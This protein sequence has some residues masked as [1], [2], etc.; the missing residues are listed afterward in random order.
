M[1]QGSLDDRDEDGEQPSPE[2]DAAR[3]TCLSFTVRGPWAHFRRVEGNIVK[4][5][6]RLIPRTTV[7]GLLAAIVG[8]SRDSYYDVFAPDGS[9]VA[10]EPVAELRTMN[11][12]QNTLSTAW[13]HLEGYNT[14][15]NATIRLPDPTEPRQQ[16]NY[17]V[18]VDPAYRIDVRLDDD[19]FREALRE[20]LA[21]GTAYYSP[22]LGLSEHLAEIE[23]HGEFEI[24]ASG[25][26]EETQ[27]DSAVVD[28]VDSVVPERGR[29]CRIERSPGYM[30]ADENGRTTTGFVSYAFAADAG[31]L[32]VR[33]V[34][35][36]SVDGRTVMFS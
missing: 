34:E 15:G 10:V 13:E 30:T 17:E 22:S 31:A 36:F 33:D 35:T 23:Y 20:R 29:E 19:A 24:D 27:V 7:A 32:T 28:A 12:P 1:R 6:Y 26:S 2:R 16:H 4:Q 18:L 8:R 14:R 11:L 5:S 25:V 9:Q 21:T 3:D